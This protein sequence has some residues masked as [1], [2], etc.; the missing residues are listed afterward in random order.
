MAIDEATNHR[1]G[2]IGGV[3]SCMAVLLLAG[4]GTT[5]REFGNPARRLGLGLRDLPAGDN[6]DRLGGLGGP[7]TAPPPPRGLS[8]GRD[9]GR[10]LHPLHSEGAY[11][12]AAPGPA[13]HPVPEPG[14]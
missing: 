3:A 7:R 12:G 8:H 9:D 11:W 10:T 4:C 6:G 5:V 14:V 13:K 2:W 1:A